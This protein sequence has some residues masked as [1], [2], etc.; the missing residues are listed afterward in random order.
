MW[1][2]IKLTQIA[3]NRTYDFLAQFYVASNFYGPKKRTFWDV[4]CDKV[5]PLEK[6]LVLT[7]QT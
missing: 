7:I 6:F 2:L 4:F 1:F 5:V 3:R